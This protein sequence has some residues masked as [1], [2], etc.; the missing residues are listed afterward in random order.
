MRIMS[1]QYNDN[2][3]VQKK[4]GQ[5]TQERGNLWMPRSK[6][7]S[8]MCKHGRLLTVIILQKPSDLIWSQVG[9]LIEMSEY[10][11][12]KWSSCPSV[13]HA[14]GAQMGREREHLDP[15][16][17][18]KSPLCPLPLGDRGSLCL[19]VPICKMGTDTVPTSQDYNGEYT[20]EHC[21]AWRT[22]FDIISI[23]CLLNN[24]LFL[25]G[26]RLLLFQGSC[27]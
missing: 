20:D 27:Y 23:M 22:V 18:L 17:G 13:F 15:D 16:H 12:R 14:K 1:Y 21:K 11:I 6:R 19:S 2:T 24:I 7:L 3:G 25:I 10:S 9:R 26:P 4:T 8:E 5:N